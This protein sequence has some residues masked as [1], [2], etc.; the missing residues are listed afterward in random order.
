M[1]P[2]EEVK[3]GD[4]VRERSGVKCGGYRKIRP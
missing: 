1:V 2:E 3:R 4:L